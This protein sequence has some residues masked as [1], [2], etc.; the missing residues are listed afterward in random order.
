MKDLI[1]YYV[2]SLRNTISNSEK[3]NLSSSEQGDWKVLQDEWEKQL[4]EKRL[5]EIRNPPRKK[6]WQK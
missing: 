5:E 2:P 1:P 6:W 4:L 3:I